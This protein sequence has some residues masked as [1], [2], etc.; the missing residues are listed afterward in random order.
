MGSQDP[1]AFSGA[2]YNS[3]FQGQ[4]M[5]QNRNRDFSDINNTHYGMD[6]PYNQRE[7]NNVRTMQPAPSQ[8]SGRVGLFNIIFGGGNQSNEYNQQ[9]AMGNR[10]LDISLPDP[11][12]QRPRS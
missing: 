3:D 9:P 7:G 8:S 1:G 5:M 12:N 4:N 10:D 6:R 11:R 2:D